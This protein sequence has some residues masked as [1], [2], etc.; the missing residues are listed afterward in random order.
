MVRCECRRDTVGQASL[1]VPSIQAQKRTGYFLSEKQRENPRLF[2]YLN[3]SERLARLR[4]SDRTA[5][6]PKVWELEPFVELENSKV[7]LY[8]PFFDR[9]AI[10]CVCL[11]GVNDFQ[12]ISIDESWWGCML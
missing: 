4:Q 9:Y 5:D 10:D 3:P 2:I 12:R 11:D 7:V 8:D 6:Q 1:T